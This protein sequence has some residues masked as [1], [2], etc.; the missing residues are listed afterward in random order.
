MHLK[1]YLS[2][3]GNARR[4]AHEPPPRFN[5]PMLIRCKGRGTGDDLGPLPFGILR[6]CSLAP[7]R[8][9]CLEAIGYLRQFLSVPFK[10]G[11]LVFITQKRR[12]EVRVRGLVVADTIEVLTV[13]GLL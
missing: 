5:D 3:R 7:P 9:P 8:Q 1:Q 10:N 12:L 13:L 2:L 6:S 11:R 4:P